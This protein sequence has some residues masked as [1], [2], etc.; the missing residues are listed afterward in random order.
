[1]GRLQKGK[2]AMSGKQALEQ[3]GGSK[4]DREQSWEEGEKHGDGLSKT[5]PSRD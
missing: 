2:A 3:E 4:E 1:M 5:Q